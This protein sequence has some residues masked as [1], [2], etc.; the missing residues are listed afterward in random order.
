MNTY[1]TE[2]G[3]VI[4]RAWSDL[5]ISCDIADEH[6]PHIFDPEFTLYK[7]YVCAGKPEKNIYDTP[8]RWPINRKKPNHE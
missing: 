7:Q 6:A 2:S 3:E 1:Y 8:P 5:S 4:G